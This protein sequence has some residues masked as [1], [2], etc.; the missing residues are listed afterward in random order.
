MKMKLYQINLER[1]AGRLA[2]APLSHMIR[3]GHVPASEIPQVPSGSY[4][5]V[6][7]GEVEATDYEDAFRVFNVDHPKGYTGRSMSVSD[8]LV[9]R[10]GAFFCDSFGFQ[11]VL[12]DESAAKH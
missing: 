8:I 10:R 1:D 12:F 7:D 4:D 3:F 2:F 5:L 6:F 9:T 11:Q